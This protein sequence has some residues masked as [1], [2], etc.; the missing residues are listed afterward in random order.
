V[1]HAEASYILAWRPR[2]ESQE[3]AVCLA[4]LILEKRQALP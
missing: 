1:A 2:D 3:V 4:V